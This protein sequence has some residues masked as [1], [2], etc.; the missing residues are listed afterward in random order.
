MTTFNSLQSAKNFLFDLCEKY[1]LC[2]KFCG[3]YETKG[4]CFQYKL[5]ECRGACVGGEES[6]STYNLRVQGI[7]DRFSFSQSD[8]LLLG[9]GGRDEDE[10]SV[11]KVETTVMLGLVY[12]ER[13]QWL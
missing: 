4:S 3:L 10:C 13:S 2:Q 11:V 12:C 9:E 5:H 1:Q 7:I 6:S 8:F